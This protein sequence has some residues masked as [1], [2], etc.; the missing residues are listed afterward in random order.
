MLKYHIQTIEVGAAGA[1]DLTFSAI[2]QIYDDLELVVSARN[3]S[4]QEHLTISFNGS[5]SNFTGRYVNNSPG[6]GVYARYLGNQTRA[7]YTANTFGNARAV[8]SNY[9]TSATKLISSETVSP[10]N[11]T[12]T[13]SWAIVFASNSWASTSPVTSLTLTSESGSNFSQY[14][15]ASLYGIRRG[16]DGVTGV[17]PAAQGGTITTSGGYTYHTFTASGTFV[18]NRSLQVEAL[19]IAGG[20]GSPDN[21]G[22]G[23]G[24]G[25]VITSSVQALPAAYQVV[26]GAGG[27]GAGGPG[28]NGFNSSA[29]GLSAV[30]GGR[31]GTW[32]N[33][34]GQTG[35]SGGGGAGYTGAGGS[36]TSG[37]GFAGGAGSGGPTYGGSGG[38]GG[39]GGA[40]GNAVSYDGGTGGAGTS[41]FS[42][43]ATATSTG[44]SGAYAGG[45]GGG[46]YNPYFT[47]TYPGGSGG[48]GGGTGNNSAAGGNGTANTGSG[49]GGGGP[50]GGD[51][52]SGGSG[53]V[54]IRYLT[55]A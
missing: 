31:G 55:P 32:T 26:I 30:G 23:S 9:T 35:G 21:V 17:L 20:G 42:T 52:G 38:G 41:A 28:S 7:A 24:A 40:G 14:T 27:A 15:S 1:A 2:P 8:I 45:G 11:A 46:S 51:G 37:Q 54:I 12:S 25:G 5:T 50:N 34:A 10:N 22:A 53:L 6:S 49:G 4:T 29:L 18:A 3:S 39:A 43:W 19:V 36:P 44:V 33:G 13:S 48:G 16:A 47:G